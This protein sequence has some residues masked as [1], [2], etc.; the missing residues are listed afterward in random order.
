MET[1]TNTQDLK[2]E[3]QKGKELRNLITIIK[4]KD[5][6]YRRNF[7]P[8]PLGKEKVN[9]QNMYVSDWYFDK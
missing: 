3:R 2:K 1:E 6:N 4:T 5:L 7:E 9:L 8:N